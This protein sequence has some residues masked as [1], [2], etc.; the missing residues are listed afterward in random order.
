M[1]SISMLSVTSSSS[2]EASRPL[3]ASAAATIAGSSPL[4]NWRDER[5]TATVRGSD[6]SRRQWAADRQARRRN[7]SP[8]TEI[9]PASSAT[10]MKRSGDTGPSRMLVQ[11]AR[12]SKPVRIPAPSTLGWKHT[13]MFS[14][15][16]ADRSS[17]S[18]RKRVC[19]CC[20]NS[21][22][23]KCCSSLPR[24]FAAYSAVSAAFSR[25]GQLSPSAGKVA[26]PTLQLTWI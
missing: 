13:T 2:A 8:R 11:R 5:L 6:D 7:C 9:S 1:F 3:S 25:L 4:S 12:A 10:G 22:E 16:I 26:T 24:L 21:T 14:D 17:V 19:T 20:A 23:K 18:S 15:W